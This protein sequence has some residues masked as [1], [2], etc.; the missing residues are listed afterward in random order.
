MNDQPLPFSVLLLAGGMSSRMRQD[1]ALLSWCGV[2]LWQFQARKLKALRPAHLFIACRQEQMLHQN[3][4]PDLTETEW[5]FDPPAQGNGPLLP[6]LNALR[7]C[8][9]PLLVLAVDMPEM[10]VAFLR[11]ALEQL[12][13]TALFFRTA[14][15]TEPLA[16]I[17]TPALIPMLEKA[18]EEARF[19][20]R[21]VID[22][23]AGLG[24]AIVPPLSP[25]DA[26]LFA[27]VNT[28][29]EWRQVAR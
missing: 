12:P 11:E 28:P 14:E 6:I 8:K 4:P 17:Y 21:R 5:L 15:G 27:N 20:L 1:K 26:A 23:A 7:L 2:P 9:T 19:S 29:G 25:P 24:L 13:E 18:A 16:G 22:E 3:T 10:T